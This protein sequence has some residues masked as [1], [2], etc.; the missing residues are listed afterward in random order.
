M[1]IHTTYLE[2]NEGKMFISL[3][4]KFLTKVIDEIKTN[5]EPTFNKEYVAEVD[6][7]T[8]KLELRG[9]EKILFVVKKD[10]QLLSF[11]VFHRDEKT[12]PFMR[13]HLI[14]EKEHENMSNNRHFF[15]IFSLIRYVDKCLHH[16]NQTKI[17]LEL[18]EEEK[19]LFFFEGEKIKKEAAEEDIALKEKIKQSDIPQ[20]T[21]EKI[22]A[23]LAP[24]YAFLFDKKPLSI[25]QKHHLTRLYEEDLP[26]LIKA[27]IALPDKERAKQEPQLLEA[28]S[29]IMTVFEEEINEATL[30]NFQKQ[31]TLFKKRYQKN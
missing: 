10:E 7:F 9:F 29:G 11:I 13:R 5:Q 20:E 8:F 17:T 3:S 30:F 14:I 24:V 21:K 25:E 1:S 18:T 26:G 4:S 19:K 2:S 6:R 31:L 28:I 23:Q 12:F 27:Y 15:P 22:Y 16:K